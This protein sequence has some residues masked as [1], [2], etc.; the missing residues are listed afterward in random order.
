MNGNGHAHTPLTHPAMVEAD[1]HA[2]I[3]TL[4]ALG[5]TISHLSLQTK[6]PIT[7][8]F[9][10][11]HAKTQQ[12]TDLHLQGRLNVAN[13]SARDIRGSVQGFSSPVS[14]SID[15]IAAKDSQF[16]IDGLHLHGEGTLNM[17]LLV[18][19][20]GSQI[21]VSA[22]GLDV[23]RLMKA[24]GYDRAPVKGQLDAKID[25][26]LAAYSQGEASIHV[27]DGSYGT[28]Q[29]IQLDTEMKVKGRTLKGALS[30]TLA[31]RLSLASSW[32][33]ESGA[34]LVNSNGYPASTGQLELELSDVKLEWLSRL[35]PESTQSMA[36]AS[37]TLDA[38]INV[39]RSDP[40]EF[41]RV[42][43]TTKTH[44][45]SL[46]TFSSS[47]PLRISGLDVDA[48]GALK[49]HLNEAQLA[50]RL[51]DSHGELLTTS[52]SLSL[53]LDEWKREPPSMEEL[54]NVISTAP[55]QALLTLT[56]RQFTDLPS[57]M[58][59]PG[60]EGRVA[61]RLMIQGTSHDPRFDLALSGKKITGAP[62]SL[63][64]EVSTVA[65]LRF[66][67]K[68]RRMA[69]TLKMQLGQAPL[70][71][72]SLD[73]TLRKNRWLALLA[74]SGGKEKPLWT[75]AVQVFFEGAPL[76]LLSPLAEQ[77]VEGRLQGVLTIER[78]DEFQRLDADLRLRRL[79]LG[80][81]SLGSGTLTA[82][83]NAE[84]LILR[85]HFNDEYGSL[86]ATGEIGILTTPLLL[87]LNRNQPA[88]VTLESNDYDAAVL[89]PLL[90]EV[91]SELSGTLRGRL[92]LEFSPQQELAQEWETRFSGYMTMTDGVITP[93]QM[94]LRLT[95][96]HLALRASREGHFNVVRIQGFR[97]KA[98]S[99]IH[100]IRGR[101]TAYFEDFTLKRTDFELFPEA[102]PMVSNQEKMADIS[103]RVQGQLNRKETRLDLDLSLGGLSVTLPTNSDRN[104]I[105]T[106]DNPTITVLQLRE[107]KKSQPQ[108]KGIPFFIQADLG[109]GVRI[110]NRLVNLELLG[111]PKLLIEDEA[112]VSGELKLKSGG[113]VQVLGKTFVIDQ[114]RI[115]F[116]GH[117]STNPHLDITASWR[118]SSGVT[119]IAD[120]TGTAQDPS[121]RWSSEPALPGGESEVMALVLG[122]GGG[123]EGNV[124]VA[125]LAA[126]VNEAI[127]ET[128][129]KNVEIYAGRETEASEGQVARL[130]ERAWNSYSASVQIS[131]ELWFEGS[132]RQESAGPETDPRSGVS[133]T[134]DWRFAP[135]WSA[136]SEVGTLGF[137]LDLMWQHR[138]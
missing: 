76:S 57:L 81:R 51:L 84:Q 101:A 23:A 85:T 120:I 8:P 123:Q 66:R 115:M 6:G 73:L 55:L 117:D 22:Q 103:G 134:L 64:E 32:N 17:D 56:E 91:V 94:G 2:Q 58:R 60:L 63:T 21:D 107:E 105:D 30:G 137:G 88:V 11:L 113:R 34:P 65:N 52:G 95:D 26:D 47:E 118:S 62:T 3:D 25:L 36:R 126:A 27:R 41:P 68:T 108:D 100:N 133:G 96:A 67:P 82:T 43:V 5:L 48:R 69:G 12:E 42:T 15:R 20:A 71:S 111:T 112:S 9:L 28:L 45:L 90:S 37:G 98:R 75:G 116:E 77:N 61:A 19:E 104:L 89:T 10:E 119:A 4:E 29:G 99:E 131:D 132:Y 46:D 14:L 70:G 72:A 80:K 87:R 129:L 97:A 40:N 53:P 127:G 102:F 135:N 59:P 79:M 138:Y 106:S 49:P 92:H 109:Q 1:L 78:N 136:R 33:L 86:D 114:G 130:S 122:G 110:E 121:I 44:E 35:L 16:S 54:G 38:K 83:T 124:G 18:S 39:E 13:S 24:V 7:E 31:D 93:T 50:L 74:G 128:G 125:Y